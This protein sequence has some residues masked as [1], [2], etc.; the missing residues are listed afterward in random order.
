MFLVLIL[1]ARTPGRKQE[2]IWLGRR[3]WRAVTTALSRARACQELAEQVNVLS[4]VLH[5]HFPLH[6]RNESLYKGQTCGGRQGRAKLVP[7]RT[8]FASQLWALQLPRVPSV[9]E[10]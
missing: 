4:S 8:R 5:S 1:D 6:S 10:L 3:A 9:K 7:Q 2:P